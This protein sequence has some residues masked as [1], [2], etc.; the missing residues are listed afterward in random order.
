MMGNTTVDNNFYEG[1][2]FEPIIVKAPRY[3]F[4]SINVKPL[5]TNNPHELYLHYREYIRYV[6]DNTQFSKEFIAGYWD[7]ETDHG[8]SRL[9]LQELNG[10]GFNVGRFNP[11]QEG[12][13]YSSDDGGSYKATFTNLKKA[14]DGWVYV[15]NLSRYKRCPTL[16]T[17]VDQC[18]CM[19]DN[20][21]HTD[22]SVKGRVQRISKYADAI[23]K[24]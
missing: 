7:F 24:Q 6:A 17:I 22:Q 20:M 2:T 11:H 10:G 8:T 12:S 4:M 14:A 9:W 13:T 3:D 1:R 19:K 16:K 23:Y 18:R 15:L 21:Y 5:D